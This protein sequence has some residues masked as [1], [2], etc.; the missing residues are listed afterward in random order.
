M[1]KINEKI[2]YT[3][4]KC[5]GENALIFYAPDYDLAKTFDCGQCFRFLPAA[6][7][8]ECEFSGVAH[9]RYIRFAKDGPQLIVI[10]ANESEAMLW[11]HYLALDADYD[12]IRGGLFARLGQNPAFAKALDIAGGI[13]ILRQERFEALCTFILSQNN[14]IPRI[15]LLVERLCDTCGEAV[16][17]AHGVF[18]AFP[19]PSALASLSVEALQGLKLGYRARYIADA[20]RRVASGELDLDGL[21]PENAREALLAVDGVGEKVASCVRLFGIGDLSACPVDVWIRRVADAYFGG[22]L[23]PLLTEK[24]GGV[25]QQYLFYYERYTASRTDK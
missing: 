21:T 25:A 4:S 15:R 6:S 23:E 16:E 12:E 13:R 7:P 24:Y 19:T 2:S 17:T 20:A 1:M 8:Y 10:G 18:R 11:A 5:D 3:V 22:D 9:G 14:N